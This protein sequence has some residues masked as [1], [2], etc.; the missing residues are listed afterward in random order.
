MLRH[1]D[2][3]C[4]PRRDQPGVA[5]SPAGDA[6]GRAGAWGTLPRCHHKCSSHGTVFPPRALSGQRQPRTVGQSLFVHPCSG[7]G[8]PCR[9]KEPCAVPRQDFRLA[10]ET[11]KAP[12]GLCQPSQR[13]LEQ[14]LCAMLTQTAR[15]E[16]AAREAGVCRVRTWCRWGCQPDL[17]SHVRATCVLCV[18]QTCT[19]PAGMGRYTCLPTNACMQQACA[20]SRSGTR[21]VLPCI[22]QS[23]SLRPAHARQRMGPWGCVL[24]EWCRLPRK[25]AGGGN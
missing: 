24:S 14:Q 13:L 21:A 12:G 16:G 17:Q 2:L 9:A 5:R 6:A 3:P 20:P 25:G 1:T 10:S 4:S 7:L 23:R 15:L 18:R 11:R 22:P 8:S 19:S